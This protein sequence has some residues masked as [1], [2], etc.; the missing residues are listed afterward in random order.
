[1]E[2]LGWV[3]SPRLLAP[4]LRPGPTLETHAVAFRC[5]SLETELRTPKV[6]TAGRGKRTVAFPLNFSLIATKPDVTT[7]A[8]LVSAPTSR[9]L[10]HSLCFL[11][12][13]LHPHPRRGTRLSASS[14]A[15]AAPGFHPRPSEIYIVTA[16][17]RDHWC[18]P[19]PSRPMIGG[20]RQV[21]CMPAAAGSP[22][23]QAAA[24]A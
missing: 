11:F 22:A 7:P 18:S 10:S 4:P 13:L 14:P 20:P 1:M 16:P 19:S 17:L 15:F 9:T 3:P 6:W 8:Y 21:I 5:R 23:V 2:R 12:P 24:A